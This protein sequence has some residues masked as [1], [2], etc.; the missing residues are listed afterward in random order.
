[1]IAILAGCTLA[2]KYA[3]PPA[4]VPAAWPSGAAY[5]GDPAATAAAAAEHLRWQE[6]VVDAKLQR[7]IAA[8]LVSNRDLRLAVL[9]V[10]R[11]RALYDIKRAELLPAVNATGSGSRQRVPADLSASGE[12]RTVEQY[13]VN[14][15]VVSWE[16]DFFGRIRSLK[17]RALEEYLATEH[18]HSSAEILLVAA[19]ANAY[20]ALAAD[21]EN[22]GL[23]EST[24]AAQKGAYDLIKRR[25]DLGLV[26]ELDLYRAQ[27]QVATSRGD[28]A[29]FAQLVAQDENALVLLVGAPLADDLLPTALADVAPLR[30]VRAGVPSEVLLRRPD[31]LQSETL[32]K[33]AHAD[34]GAARAAFFPR[35]ALTGAVGTAS[36]ELSGLFGSGSGTWS[37]A[38]Q[39]V[40]PVFDARTW[41]AHRAANVQREIALTQYE[42]AVQ[43]A[44][45]EVADALAQRGTVGEQLAAQ[46]SL[47]EAA[48]ATYRLAEE[49][50][51]R[52]VDNY[53]TV[54]DAHRSLYGAQ[55][56]LIGLRLARIANSL[57][58]YKVLAGG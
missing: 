1:M 14:L 33:A 43:V 30:E 41:S 23:A 11:T 16:L 28:V 36:A 31:V 35:I 51:N 18:A 47:V 40:L 5:P 50:Y 52:G 21:R 58:L 53:L 34:L 42:R 57:T 54:L 9:N 17:A 19:V 37:F 46:A 56:G 44:F 27:T 26:P 48:T 24:L 20:L 13:G 39:I 6:V 38:P 29:R 8:A 25:C 2:P 49:R 32:L 10:E 15:G 45:R 7:V 3:R 4:P 22:L 12:R 55:Q